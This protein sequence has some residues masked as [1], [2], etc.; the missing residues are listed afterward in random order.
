LVALGAPLLRP[1]VGLHA[2]GIGAG[3]PVPPAGEQTGGRLATLPAAAAR[4][5]SNQAEPPPSPALSRTTQRPD[6][7]VIGINGMFQATSNGF[8]ADTTLTQYVE[9]GRLTA[10]YDSGRPP[11]L[12]VDG[13]VYVWRRLSVG[14]A[15]TWLT[16]DNGGSL[17]AQV[18]HPFLF[19]A[20]R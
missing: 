11:G 5:A 13:A 18:P 1:P 12:D 8:T 3:L 2:Q 16:Q 9:A 17:T 6:R 14:A 19:G 4:E 10:T 20:P 7:G 15:V